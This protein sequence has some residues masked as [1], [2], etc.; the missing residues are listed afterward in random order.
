MH[1][2]LYLSESLICL[3]RNVIVLAL[4]V[5]SPEPILWSNCKYQECQSCLLFGFQ[6][7]PEMTN[8]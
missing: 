7:T 4:G 5:E 3:N 1:L 6:K 2:G 8:N